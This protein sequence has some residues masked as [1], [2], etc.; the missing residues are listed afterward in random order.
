M[1]K[2]LVVDG[3]S[4]LFRAYHATKFGN[5]MKSR[6]GVVTNA[7]FAFSNM[8]RKA[9]ESIQPDY[10]VVAFDTGSKTFRHDMYEAYKGT[11]SEP[12]EELIAQFEL[13]REFL[14]AYP[15]ERIEIEGYEAD[16]IIGTISKRYPDFEIDILTSDRDMLQLI[17]TNV[18]V[19]LMKK[20]FSEIK[21]MTPQLLEEEM[22]ITPKQVIDLKAL[23]GDTSDNI[24][25]IPSVGEKTGLKLLAQYN[26]LDTIYEN[27]ESIKGKLGEKIRE[28]KDN[29]YLS[30]DLAKIR[31]D[32]DFDLDL[33]KAKSTRVIETLNGFYRKYDMNSLL[34]EDKQ[35]VTKK[36]IVL[37]SLDKKWLDKPVNIAVDINK[38]EEIIGC[39]LYSEEKY[40]YLTYEEM[41]QNNIFHTLMMQDNVIC[42]STKVL[43][44]FCLDQALPY[45]LHDDLILMAFIVDSS[46]TKESILKDKFELWFYGYDYP[47]DLCLYAQQIEIVF[48]TLKEQAKKEGTLDI[49]ETIEKPL[50]PVLA[51]CEYYGFNV[52]Q[53]ILDGIAEETKIKLDALTDQ[54]YAITGKE[55]NI[56]SP[57]QL[58]EVLFDE[59]GLPQLKKRSTAAEV[60][61]ALSSEHEIM[62]LLLEYRKY[63]KLYSTY[64]TGLIKHIVDG[65]IHTHLNQHATQTG[66]LSSS[67]PNLQ[68]ISVRDE[69]TRQ[70]RKAF[71][72]SPGC[73][74]LS[75]DYSQIE[76]RVLSFLAQEKTMMDGFNQNIDVHTLTATQIFGTNEVD[77]TMR[78]QAKTVNFG[79]VYGISDF[80]LA[81]QLDIP[82]KEAKS[83]IETYNAVYPSITSYMESI[84]ENCQEQGYVTTFF[85]RRRAIPEI[86]NKNRAIQEFGKRAAMNAPI[87]GTAADIIKLAMIKADEILVQGHYK[88]KM[89]LQVHD[90]LIFDVY[91]D[92]LETIT[93]LMVEMMESVVDWPVKLQVAYDIG[94]DWF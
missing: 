25:G 61:E 9:L 65:K 15:I 34:L 17:D 59:L 93:K 67:D 44:K 20:G 51:K 53:D 18:N 42:S 22:G 49:Y 8:L 50:A 11:R 70:I 30:Y 60:L 6:E 62:P 75:I 63:Q 68:N 16:D 48:N 55:F 52:R 47:T 46:I 38:E 57:K 78:R 56:N 28:H 43:Y 90:E 54:I 12:D 84:I 69:E 81:K 92:E 32:V 89:I 3:N 83:F 7:I 39:G 37:V 24:P 72:A 66:R 64:A 23:M 94:K 35:D 80:G 14:D 40:V 77:S 4:I 58:A 1:E 86:H 79:I 29:A 10:V 73:Q 82:Q 21:I 33:E 87:Q 45:V 71:V 5:I 91:E 36:D 26:N 41:K 13:V 27:S 88:S 19:V 76:L 85:G 2:L 31:C 74:L